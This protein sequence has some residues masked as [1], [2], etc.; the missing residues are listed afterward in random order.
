VGRLDFITWIP[1]RCRCVNTLMPAAAV[2]DPFQVRE[3]ALQMASVGDLPEQLEDGA[4][5]VHG[6]PIMWRARIRSC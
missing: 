1:S 4:R 6:N 2:L 3:D 5:G